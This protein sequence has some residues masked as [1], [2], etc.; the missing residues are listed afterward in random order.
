MSKSPTSAR[1]EPRL[2]LL[3]G[4]GLVDLNHPELTERLAGIAT[5]QLERFQARMR[6]G[7][8]AASVA[9]GLGVLSEFLAAE[10]TEKAGPKGRHNNVVL[11]SRGAPLRGADPRNGARRWFVHR[12]LDEMT[13]LGGSH[14][15]GK[16]Q[17]Q[18]DST[19]R[20]GTGTPAKRAAAQVHGVGGRREEAPAPPDP[21]PPSAA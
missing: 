1:V 13:G 5:A 19:A 8:L 11:L 15:T 4:I 21:E 18:E 3:P 12:H 10:V 20:S 16:S 7:L 14:G 6:D 2:Q 9:V 17:G